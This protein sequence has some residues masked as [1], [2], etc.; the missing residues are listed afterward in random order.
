MDGYSDKVDDDD[1]EERYV[2]DTK[3]REF[4]VLRSDV[5]RG[6]GCLRDFS[7]SKEACRICCG[8]TAVASLCSMG[9]GFFSSSILRSS[10][11]YFGVPFTDNRSEIISAAGFP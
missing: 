11:Y 5:G 6:E 8:S 3:E 9:G 4:F 2:P 10:S 1:E 7:N